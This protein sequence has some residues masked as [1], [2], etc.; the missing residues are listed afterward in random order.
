MLA[1]AREKVPGG[2]FHEADLHDLPLPDD[3]VDVVVCAIALV[4]LPD[5][6]GPLGEFARVLRSGGH[7]VVSDQC[8]LTGDI[9][10]PLVRVGPDDEISYMPVYARLA[11]EYLAAALPLGFQGAQVRGAASPLP[12]LDQGR[13]TVGDGV[14]LGPQDPHAPPWIWALHEEAI[15]STNAAWRGEPSSII[16]LFRLCGE[17]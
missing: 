8:G 15:D 4:H 12:L 17:Q 3:S 1:R 16:W 9:G 6:E 10:L 5:L 14:R 7:L 13:R 2:T 11:S